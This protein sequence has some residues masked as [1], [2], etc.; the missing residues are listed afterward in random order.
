MTESDPIKRLALLA[1]HLAY[2]HSTIEKFPSKPFNPLLGET[3][4]YVVPGKYQFLAEQVSHHP[5]ITAY[6]FIGESGYV[7]YLTNRLKS[8]VARGSLVFGNM[9][10]EYIELLPHGEMFEVNPPFIGIHNLI[11]GSPYLEPDTKA[12][13]KNVKCPKEQYAEIN[14]LK[15]GWS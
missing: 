1:C 10:K 9:Y 2:Q 8:K 14:F 6:H 5:P 7:R 12:I 3:Y 11:I 13:I 4:E 15:R